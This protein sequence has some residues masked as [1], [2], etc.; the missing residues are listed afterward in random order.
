MDDLDVIL[1]ERKGFVGLEMLNDAVEQL[2]QFATC[3]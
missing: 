2:R 3:R 1:R